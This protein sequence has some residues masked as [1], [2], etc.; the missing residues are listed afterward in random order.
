VPN[1]NHVL[2]LLVYMKTLAGPRCLNAM[3]INSSGL[4]SIELE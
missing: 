4:Y 1:Y 2:R 3:Y